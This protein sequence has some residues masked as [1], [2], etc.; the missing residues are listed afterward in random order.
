MKKLIRII[1]YLLSIH[2]LA[3]FILTVF[4]CVL[5]WANL[6]QVAGMENRRGLFIQALIM[7]VRFDNLIACYILY[8]PLV[9]LSVM[10]LFNNISKGVVK[11]FNIY[12]II[13]YTV[14]FSISAADIPYFKYFF[15]HLDG[16]IFNWTGFGAT[17]MGMIFQESSYYIYIALFVAMAVL[18]G[19]AVFWFGKKAY[20][21]QSVNLKKRDYYIA[22]PLVIILWGV[23]FVGGRGGLERYPLRVSNAYFS[24]NS[25]FNQLGVNPAFYLMKTASAFF[26][27]HNNLEGVMDKDKALAFV[28]DVLHTD[29][30]NGGNPIGR[31]VKPYSIPL[32]AN[33]VIILME[34][35]SAEYLKAESNGKPLTPYLNELIEKSYYYDNFYSS[36][37]HTNNGIASTLYGYPAQ[38]D[39]T[40]M[41]VSVDHYSGLPGNLKDRG[42]QT[43]FFLT[44]NPQYDNMNSFLM[45]NGFDRIYSQ[46]DYPNEKIVNNFGV[47]DD[48][49]FEYG[50]EQ[51]NEES[52]SGKPFLAAFMT[53][54]NH[55]PYI[56]PERFK[57]ISDNDE[58]CIIAFSDACIRL[59]MESA[60]QQMWYD[61]TIFVILG[62]HG[63]SIGTQIYDMP[64]SYNHI[65][66]IIYSPLFDDMP[67][68]FEQFGG[69]IDVYPTVMGLLNEPYQNNSLGIDLFREQR[70]YI[71][72]VSNNR[73]G[74]ID[75]KFFYMFNPQ[76]KIDG[77]YDY[78]NGNPENLINEHHSVADSMK[79]YSVS[80][81]VTADYLVT[82][83]FD[84]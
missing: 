25:F 1:C 45:E 23:C 75:D 7:G 17:T 76:D 59:F 38:F 44:S 82:S 28:Q 70:P 47:Q 18:F 56:V 12:F 26:K 27:K 61:N 36:G 67:K 29:S 68:R 83:D 9:V 81:M 60:A 39:K 11:A 13:L 71:Y 31:Y 2:L 14:V 63:R 65:P 19:L 64:L 30:I 8:L 34:S 15:T 78:R 48:Y 51:L 53:V 37:I 32:N 54:S 79:Q 22:I 35:M 33:V 55:P 43:M 84:R 52:K 20:T 6:E 5:Y 42:Y 80:M 4:R 72:F 16:A 57:N 49:L 21:I 62:D 50:I 46:Y 41:G 69:Q 3:L 40:M 24:K 73:L 77:L 10:A 58:S 74:C 66:L